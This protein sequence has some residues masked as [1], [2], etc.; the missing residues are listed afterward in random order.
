MIDKN[1]I[2]F[3][4]HACETT[5]TPVMWII[6]TDADEPDTINSK[7]AYS[8]RQTPAE[9]RHMCSID[10]TTGHHRNRHNANSYFGYK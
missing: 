5:G 9:S 1:V 6:A 2:S 10:K 8:L 4:Q 7:I 3:C